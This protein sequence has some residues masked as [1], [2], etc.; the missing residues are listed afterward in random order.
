[1]H[2]TIEID[3]KKVVVTDKNARAYEKLNGLPVDAEAVK[4][5]ISAACKGAPD[6]NIA[7]LSEEDLSNLVNNSIEMEVRGCGSDAF[8]E[9]A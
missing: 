8:Y 6:R 3:G 5:Y 4:I 2:M 9:G 1:M 7:L